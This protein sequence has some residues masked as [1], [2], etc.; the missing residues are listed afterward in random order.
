MKPFIFA[1]LFITLSTN[2]FAGGDEE[3]N[4]KVM[5]KEI[6]VSQFVFVGKLV[7]T[8][9]RFI[10]EKLKV[11]DDHDKKIW[12]AY[13]SDRYDNRDIIPGRMQV[14]AK[15]A[16]SKMLLG[17]KELVKP[18][19]T[20]SWLEPTM[21]VCPHHSS[22]LSGKERIWIV[23]I[24]DDF[25]EASLRSLPIEHLDEVKIMLKLTKDNK[26]E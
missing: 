13:T 5:A 11:V 23:V 3:N 7:V 6:L 19:L 4:P 25:R 16:P 10:T 22:A 15:V 21:V 12:Q 1:L 2:I 14:W 9:Y 17:S 26:Q 24:S 18:F 20:E 8:D